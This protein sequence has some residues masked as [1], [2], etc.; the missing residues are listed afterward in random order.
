MTTLRRFSPVMIVALAAVWSLLVNDFSP[1]TIVFGLL[2]G[3]GITALTNA[4]WPERPRIRNPVAVAGFVL[5][6]LFDILVANL[7][8]AYLILFH[9]GDSLRS[10]FVTVPLE[11]KSPE[12]IAVLASTITMTPGTLTA[13]V[14]AD[15]RALLV[16]CLDT[17][18]PS[19]TVAEI[20]SRYESRLLRIFE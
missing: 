3:A 4:Y 6:V 18:D 9:R 1:A 17:A 8:V 2:L 5:V 11:L 13:D 19:A 15:G 10:R 7:Q 12:A 20:K 14:S 16:H